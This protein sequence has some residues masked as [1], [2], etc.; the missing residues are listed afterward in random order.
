MPNLIKFCNQTI[1]TNIVP[2]EDVVEVG[3]LDILNYPFVHLTGHGNI[4]FNNAE[5]EN[6]RNYLLAGGFLHADDN[7]GM[8]KFFRREMQKVFPELSFVELPYNHPI[9]QQ[10]FKFKS[11]APMADRFMRTFTRSADEQTASR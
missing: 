1:G 11:S 5:V 7:Y 4:V 9:Y 6:L 8:D 3:S 2:E 10:K